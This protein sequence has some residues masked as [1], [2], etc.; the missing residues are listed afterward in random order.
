MNMEI[1]IERLKR[2]LFASD[3]KV[4]L[5]SNQVWKLYASIVLR[6]IKEHWKVLL[7]LGMVV[8]AYGPYVWKLVQYL[9]YWV[10]TK[11]YK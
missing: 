4:T 6:G 3:G 2:V 10:V 8:P 1:I 7:V 5:S 11:M 9:F